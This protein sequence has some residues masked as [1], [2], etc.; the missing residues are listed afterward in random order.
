MKL[1]NTH[2]FGSISNLPSDSVYI[3]RP[4]EFGNRYSSKK[5]IFTREECVALN[6]VDLYDQLISEPNYLSYIKKSLL[7]KNLAC[8]CVNTKK[9]IACHGMN[10]IHILSSS[11]INRV[12]DKS[13]IYYLIDDLKSIISFLEKKITHDVS[14][15]SYLFLYLRLGDVKI[16][17]NDALRHLKK[18]ER[19]T[20]EILFF[21]SI[22]VI[23]LECAY[24]EFKAEM[25]DYRLEHAI[26]VIRRFINNR[27]D[28]AFEPMSPDLKLKKIS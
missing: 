27:E 20:N 11:N 1:L 15:E 21:L 25:I 4:S 17:I 22:L 9:I 19:L 8:W 7:G 5:G 23:D 24:L 6:R 16:E 26:W 28:R 10:Y 12:Y 18:T 3:G 13:I 2:H 14:V